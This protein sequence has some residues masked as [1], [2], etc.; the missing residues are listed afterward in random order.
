LGLFVGF[1]LG[2]FNGL[3]YPI[4]LTGNDCGGGGGGGGGGCG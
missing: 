3:P 2:P 1:V 4:N